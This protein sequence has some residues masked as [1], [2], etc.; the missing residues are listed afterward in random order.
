M[1]IRYLVL[2]LVLVSL[3]SGL[4]A[5]S[6]TPPTQSET[7][8]LLAREQFSE[9]DQRYGAIQQAYKD[10]RISDEDLRAAF[11]A[12]YA[13]DAALEPKYKAWI[14]HSP[15][16][17][18]AHLARGIYFKKVG[19][20][21]RGGKFISETSEE[22]INGMEAAYDVAAAEF[23]ASRALD[24]R[25][26]L[27]YL[28]SIDL[29]MAVG[30]KEESR[31]LLDLAVTIDPRNFIVREKY[32]GSLQTRWGGSVDEM[33]AFLA[34]CRHAGLSAS[35]LKALEALVVEDEGWA[36][37]YGDGDLHA[38]ARA[39]R[40]AAKL[41]PAKS[42]LPCG[43]LSK[44]ADALLEA[45]DYKGAVKLYSKVLGSDPKSIHA[46]DSRAF[47]ELQLQH[48]KAALEDL[49]QAAGQGDAYA[50]DL[51]GRMYLLGTSVPQDRDKAIEWLQKAADQGY[52]PAHELL[53]LALDKNRTPMQAP[54]GPRF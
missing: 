44:A 48:P 16:S 27:T 24:D 4:R 37:Q 23:D 54:G 43:P 36:H 3:C 39:Y 28:H 17:Y 53:P 10:G 42:C 32:M 50:Q 33:K 1:R 12:F 14:Q 15:K 34:E 9:L 52:E 45:K 5:E 46:L 41:D 6:P 11:R 18:V 25:P 26:L 22:Q 21:R 40:K 8:D 20:E 7:L 31:R 47:A 30:D 13:T 35:H 19:G 29:N 38:A 49:L 2:A 51:L